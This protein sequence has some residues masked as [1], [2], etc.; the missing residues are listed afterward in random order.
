[1]GPRRLRR[2][3]SPGRPGLLGLRALK[4]S[5]VVTARLVR[6]ELRVWRARGER[7]ALPVRWVPQVLK[8]RPVRRGRRGRMAPRVR[9]V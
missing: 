9:R 7:Q 1:M 4:G 5:P 2:R 3:A 8:V 6:W